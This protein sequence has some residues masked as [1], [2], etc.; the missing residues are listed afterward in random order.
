MYT[1]I[2]I[3][4]CIYINIYIYIYIHTQ[5]HKQTLAGYETSLTPYSREHLCDGTVVR[6]LFDDRDWFPGNIASYDSVNGLYRIEF[7]DG[8]VVHA[9]HAVFDKV[10]CVCIYMCVCECV[11]IYT[12]KKRNVYVCI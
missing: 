7:D 6:M 1:Y 8:E 3:Y 10:C 11:Y 12:Y 5:T 9:R 4:V 2:R